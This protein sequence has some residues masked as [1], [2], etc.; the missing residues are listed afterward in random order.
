MTA[1]VECSGEGGDSESELT[2]CVLIVRDELYQAGLV[3]LKRLTG[4]S[5]YLEV[6]CEGCFGGEGTDLPGGGLTDTNLG[7]SDARRFLVG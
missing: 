6:S 5:D 1:F 4:G 7:L 2:R 3:G